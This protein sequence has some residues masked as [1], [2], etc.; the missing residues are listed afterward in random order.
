MDMK[1][2][3]I[4]L[5]NTLWESSQSM[6]DE[7]NKKDKIYCTSQKLEIHEDGKVS[8]GWFYGVHIASKYIKK[9]TKCPRCGILLNEG[10]K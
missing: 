6:V 5:M 9:N 1:T 10:E 8:D 3:L 4:A 7:M 2:A